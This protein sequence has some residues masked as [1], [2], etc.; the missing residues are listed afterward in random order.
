VTIDF[1]KL[2]D[3]DTEITEKQNLIDI[4]LA[5]R[6]SYPQPGDIFLLEDVNVMGLQWVV[7][8]TDD[9]DLILTVPADDNPMVGGFDVELEDEALCVPLILRCKHNLLIPKNKFNLNL[10]V[11]VV[12]DVYCLQALDLISKIGYDLKNDIDDDVYY[13]EWMDEIA[14]AIK[15]LL[16]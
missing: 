11:G 5:N 15:L 2:Y 3:I 9:M 1:N 6:P 10:R 4:E 13:Q 16:E 8:N 7:L 12:E 14:R